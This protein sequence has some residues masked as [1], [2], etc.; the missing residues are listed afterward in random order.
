MCLRSSFFVAGGTDSSGYLSAAE[1][2]LEGEL[3]APAP[4]PLVAT[5]PN[6]SAAASPVAYRPGT[7]D[8][9]DV[10]IYPLGLPVFLA[11]ARS[12]GGPLAPFVVAPFFAAVLTWCAFLVGR[13]CAGN[14]AG[15]MAA[16]LV[17]STPVTLLHAVDTMSDVPAAALWATAWG[18]ALG[19]HRSGADA[20]SGSRPM[21]GAAAA[22]AAAAGAILIRPNLAPLAMVPALLL[23]VPGPSARRLS[24]WRWVDAALFAAVA[25]IGPLTVVWSQNVLYGDPFVPGY[26]GWEQFFRAAHIPTNLELYPRLLAGVHTPLVLAGLVAPLLHRSRIAFSALAIVAIN[27]ALYLPYLPFDDWPFLRFL[28][29]GLAALFVLF[30]AL[31]VTLVSWLGRGTRWAPLLAL[32]PVA[33][34]VW[35]AE[36]QRRFA[37][38]EWR[39]QTRVRVMG[40]YL[41]EALPPNAAVLSFAHSGAVRYYTGRQVVR[42]DLLEP[43]MLDDVI[44]ELRRKGFHP[45]FVLDERYESAAFRARFERSRYG[46]LDWPPRAVFT[47]VT[48]IWYL[49]P[50]DHDRAA[51]GDRWMGDVLSEVR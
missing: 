36:P 47:S 2:W 41:R 40:H 19:L 15:L 34:V 51:G 25:A 16:A 37:L 17:G 12:V 28:L 49:D 13:A 20:A 44:E 33:L 42:L 39:A 29:P 48:A 8:G 50:A 5:W 43:A 26:P 24:S 3:F 45:V 9:T 6:A 32:V 27:F 38:G 18:V 31:V 7:I 10:P 30:S 1:R 46:R 4:L 14:L 23:L 21:A 35:Q 22:G 11:A